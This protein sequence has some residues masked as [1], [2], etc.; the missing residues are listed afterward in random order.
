METD[1]SCA[2]WHVAHEKREMSSSLMETRPC[3]ES[4]V[5]ALVSERNALRQRGEYAAADALR[6]RLH[7][8]GFMT[9][10]RL[11][12]VRVVN[13]ASSPQCEAA[14]FPPYPPTWHSGIVSTQYCSLE[15]YLA[16]SA[17]WPH[18]PKLQT[19]RELLGKRTGE[20]LAL[21]ERFGEQLSEVV[22]R[23]QSGTI[24]CVE[25]PYLDGFIRGYAQSASAHGAPF[26]LLAIN[27]GDSPLTTETQERLLSLS[28]L[29]ACYANNMHTPAS[30]AIAERIH[31]LPLGVSPIGV[32]LLAGEALLRETCARALPWA[33][34]DRRLLVTA[35]TLNSRA[36]EAYLAVLSHPSFAHLVRL[37]PGRLPL[38]AF[39]RL[40]AEHQ[41]VLS[42]PGRGYDC[43]RTWQALAV[44]TTPLLPRYAAYD[45][46][47]FDI[48]PARLP[49][50]EALTPQ[51]LDTLLGS[52]KEADS[53]AVFL[54]Y[55][56]ARWEKHLA[57]AD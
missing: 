31:P 24:L 17:A 36:R 54:E 6:E 55:W 13:A 22:Q 42:P 56:A 45:A 30:A 9:D 29:R 16:R 21:A 3:D 23:G 14:A 38:P 10:D 34:R 18:V 53:Q 2:P 8:M 57:P 15:G 25:K 26:V 5:L 19:Y 27:G 11:G 52:L 7:T 44:G 12:S 35:M 43:F 1:D 47:I 4:D 37:Q 28:G 48:G 50:P 20:R 39:L 41:T 51:A 33:Q 46:R 32:N 49:P 40:L